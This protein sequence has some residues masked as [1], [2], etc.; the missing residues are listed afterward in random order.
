MDRRIG[1]VVIVALAAAGLGDCFPMSDSSPQ[2]NG[3]GSSSSG[4][5][6]SST[7]SIWNRLLALGLVRQTTYRPSL[8]ET[9]AAPGKQEENG[10]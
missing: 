7:S 5:S 10:I 1:W 4:Y 8:K 6:S 3:S 9:T 2:D